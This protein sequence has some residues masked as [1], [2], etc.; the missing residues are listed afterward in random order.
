MKIF[1]LL[2]VFV[3]TSSILFAQQSGK[4]TYNIEMETT[5][6]E[7]Q[8]AMQ[9]M[10]GNFDM[11]VVSYYSEEGFRSEM[12][13][14]FMTT[15]TISPASGDEVL[16]LMDGMIGKSAILSETTEYKTS[17]GLKDG[18]SINLEYTDETKEI[19]G[20]TCKKALMDA[21][22][23]NEMIFWYTDEI[24]PKRLSPDMPGGLPGVPLEYTMNSD[25]MAMNFT[26]TDIS[27]EPVDA[28]KFNM[29]IP[30]GYKEMDLKALKKMG[31]MGF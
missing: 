15:T 27:F 24:N 13:N 8:Q 6:P 3:L 29:D 20:Y 10:G 16:I 25:E 22:K 30:A 11:Q 19:M 18:E 17:K 2:L 28:S 14:A 23:D 1:K 7:I 21:G 9:M 31:G 12:T 26:V 4:I 5:N